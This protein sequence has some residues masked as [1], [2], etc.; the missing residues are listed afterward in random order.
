MTLLNK[1]K[2]TNYVSK[3]IKNSSQNN[4]CFPDVTDHGWQNIN[5]EY[6][7]EF[8]SGPSYPENVVEFL[9]NDHENKTD[10]EEEED[11]EPEYETDSDSDFGN[12]DIDDSD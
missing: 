4:I 12:T 10:D 9:K 6:L 3:M 8:F 5:G 11:T 1:I 7:I 2:R